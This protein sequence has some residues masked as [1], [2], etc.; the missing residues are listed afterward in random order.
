MS[1]RLT[2]AAHPRAHRKPAC[3]TR[4]MASRAGIFVSLTLSIVLGIAGAACESSGNLGPADAAVLG[5][6]PD[7][8]SLG[9]IDGQAVAPGYAC[10]FE[11][12]ATYVCPDVTLPPPAWQPQCVDGDDCKSRVNGTA[13][14]AGCTQTTAYQDV[15]FLTTTCAS[16]TASGGAE[17]VIDSGPLPACAP[18]NPG[19]SA[20]K[21]HTPRPR[22]TACTKTQID[23]YRQ[24]LD[25]SAIELHP[26]S[27]AEWTSLSAADQSCL[28][29]LQSNQSDATYGALVLLPTEVLVNVAG[30]I[31]LAEGKPDG[32]GCGGA[33]SAD[34]QCDLAACLPT[35]PTA[36][37]NEVATESAC[38]QSANVLEAGVCA[39]FVPAAEC[40]GAIE[41][42]DAGAAGQSCFGL[43]SGTSDAVFEAVALAFCGGG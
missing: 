43:P 37:A 1:T 20:P 6:G 10:A 32:S 39:A 31:A 34:Q 38:E 13:T 30:C 5:L 26:P 36:T 33:L 19:T 35:C 14:V 9:E 22:T 7:G 21:W 8:G 28:T 11:E 27:C 41:A 23:S 29:C 42:S 24:C 40:A 18:G 2:S 25:D 4:V 17:P 12:R 3:Y 15:T 16:W